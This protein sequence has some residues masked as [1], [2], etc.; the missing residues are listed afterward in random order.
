ML[1]LIQ[2]S[3]NDIKAGPS[4][5]SDYIFQAVIQRARIDSSGNFMVGTT[6]AFPGDGDTNTGVSLTSLALLF[7]RDGLELFQLIEILVMVLQLNSIKMA[8]Q[9]ELFQLRHQPHH[10]THHQMQD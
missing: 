2:V 10:T 4:T 5:A 3:G 7:S 6:D 9:L 1:I 8:Q